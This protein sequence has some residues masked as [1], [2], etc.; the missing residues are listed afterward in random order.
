MV[1]SPRPLRRSEAMIHSETPEPEPATPA[2]G[3]GPGLLWVT[4][5]GGSAWGVSLL[6]VQVA[7]ELKRI[8][9]FYCG[10]G[11]IVGLCAGVVWR[12]MQFQRPR[13]RAL[14]TVGLAALACLLNLGYVSY[15]SFE[16][17]CRRAARDPQQILALQILEAEAAANPQSTPSRRLIEL[18]SNV[19]PTYTVYLQ[20]RLKQVGTVP[21]FGAIAVWGLEL[22]AAITLAVL[23][24]RAM[25]DR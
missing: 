23:T 18:R 6:G 8:G 21:E 3:L 19:D 10:L 11:L 12:H 15:Q 16:R 9:L 7:P 4:L 13:W 20:H 1:P 5:I 22:L 14:A 2:S 25:S 17:E 24:F